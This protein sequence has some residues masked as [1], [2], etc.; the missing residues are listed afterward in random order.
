M[1]AFVTDV[2]SNNAAMPLPLRKLKWKFCH[3]ICTSLYACSSFTS[4][5]F[6]HSLR[7]SNAFIRARWSWINF[8]SSFFFLAISASIC[9]CFQRF[10][11]ASSFSAWSAA[12]SAAEANEMVFFFFA[13]KACGFWAR[14][15]CC[16][17]CSC[18]SF[19]FSSS[20]SS[21]EED[22]SNVKMPQSTT[23][24]FCF[25]IRSCFA[26]VASTSGLGFFTSAF[27][28]SFLLSSSKIS[29]SLITSSSEFSDE[30]PTLPGPIAGA[31]F[32]ISLLKPRLN[33][34]VFSSNTLLDSIGSSSSSISTAA[35]RKRERDGWLACIGTSD[36][37]FSTFTLVAKG[38]LACI[39]T[40]VQS[41]S[42]SIFFSL[43]EESNRSICWLST[44]IFSFSSSL[45][46]DFLSILLLPKN[47][48]S[49][50]GSSSSF[51]SAVPAFMYF[52]SSCRSSSCKDMPRS[53]LS[54][55]F[56]FL[57]LPRRS[58][59]S[60]SFPF[61]GCCLNMFWNISA[62]VGVSETFTAF[63]CF[64]TSSRDFTL[65]F[66]ELCELTLNWKSFASF[67]I[68]SKSA[69]PLFGAN[70]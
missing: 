45:L 17:C 65:L 53:L 2:A 4:N 6:A 68:W 7:S 67:F 12:A 5:V 25:C 1:H 40:S 34:N 60:S 38:G 66:F 64:S 70:A 13:T 28:S 32:K 18:C 16:G 20:C 50:S 22:E 14:C 35:K 57:W 44:R 47:I 69:R 63:D 43:A 49:P 51:F 9:F 46:L 23:L 61:A 36:Q 11:S 31:A 26:I 33:P 55:S 27:L 37:C 54:L 21:S 41:L 59:T 62:P 15:C 3:A 56:F 19:S 10:F 39:G 58:N 48:A 30:K 52:I 29:S 42:S 24:N 8:S